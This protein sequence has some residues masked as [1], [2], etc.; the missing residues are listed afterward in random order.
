MLVVLLIVGLLAS[1]GLPRLQ[2]LATS[3]EMANQRQSLI[4]QIDNLPY[5]AYSSAREITLGTDPSSVID[6]P[7]D[8]QLKVARPVRYSAIG[9]CSGGRVTLIDPEGGQEAFELKAPFCR[10]GTNR[11]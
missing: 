8:W 7:D 10:I 1:I 2:R 5:Q 11:T 9:V 6:M 4:G 3:L